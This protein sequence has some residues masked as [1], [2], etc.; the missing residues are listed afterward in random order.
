MVRLNKKFKISRAVIKSPDVVILHAVEELYG[1]IF[2]HV[3]YSEIKGTDTHRV[4]QLKA[5]YTVYEK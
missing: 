2:S 1:R 5:A 3:N 4:F